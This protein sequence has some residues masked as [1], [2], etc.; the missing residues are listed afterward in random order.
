MIVVDV[1]PTCQVIR[2]PRLQVTF[3]WVE[4][5]WI[6]AIERSGAT[7][8]DASMARSFVSDPARDGADLVISPTFQQLHI[9]QDGPEH[10]VALLV[11]MSGPHHFSATCAVQADDRASTITWDVADRN[12]EARTPTASTYDLQ[13]DP[14]ALRSSDPGRVAWPLN[15]PDAPAGQFALEV[16]DESNAR[17]SVA[18]LGRRGVQAQI[19]YDGPLDDSE[20]TRRYRYRWTWT[21]TA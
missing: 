8:S 10:A 7:D 13:V 9:Q 1:E 11:G 17:L 15:D 18:A 2:A 3:R 6:H 19:H 14:G 16:V 21:P 20:P 4:D 12:R 5:R